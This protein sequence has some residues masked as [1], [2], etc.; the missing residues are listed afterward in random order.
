MKTTKE[1]IEV[2]QAYE[3]GEKIEC[4]NDGEQWRDVNSPIWDW[5]H[6]DY[7]VKPKRMFLPLEKAEDFLEAQRKHGVF[8]KRIK[9][10]VLFCSYVYYT[11][12]VLLEDSKGDTESTHIGD[13]Y[14]KYVFEDGTPCGK[15]IRL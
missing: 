12:R 1:M 14:G 9:D 4:F 10:G 3:R 8:V 7:R 15:E 6:N 13:L 11:G 2:M 5:L